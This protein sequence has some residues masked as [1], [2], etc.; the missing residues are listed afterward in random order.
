MSKRDKQIQEAIDRAL[1][2]RKDYL[3][4]LGDISDKEKEI[5]NRIKTQ[6]VENISVVKI[7]EMLMN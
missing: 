4:V 7:R 1:Q 5:L 2:G 6:I 3:D